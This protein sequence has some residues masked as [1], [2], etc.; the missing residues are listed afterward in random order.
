[1]W[2]ERADYGHFFYRIPD[3]ES[4]ADAYDRISGFN[5]SLWRR[6]D[7]DDFASVCILVTHGLMSRVFLMKWYHY[8]VEYF[9]DLRN[10][11]H[12]E[13]I[14]MRRQ[15]GSGKYVLQNKL[16]TWSELKRER[17]AR[18]S[19]SISNVLDDF[20]VP[21]R[22]QWG[23][24]PQGCSH[25]EHQHST[26][27]QLK[28]PV[29]QNTADLFKDDAELLG[30]K[31]ARERSPTMGRYPLAIEI[32]SESE[33][34]QEDTVLDQDPEKGSKVMP[35]SPSKRYRLVN[36]STKTPSSQN[37]PQSSE[38]LQSR[39]GGGENTLT[40]IKSGEV[41]SSPEWLSPL[42]R[43]GSFREGRDGGGS[44][45]GANSLVGSSESDEM[46]AD[47]LDNMTPP[48][49]PDMPPARSDTEYQTPRA[50]VVSPNDKRSMA[51]ALSGQLETVHITDGK[52]RDRVLA[53][54]LGDQSDAEIEEMDGG[55]VKERL[56]EDEEM[57]M[58]IQQEELDRSI[59]GS[60]Y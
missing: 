54:A 32:A 8:S 24:C 14:V 16:R 23:G 19:V 17:E 20:E 55:A 12:C 4:A 5:D 10:V 18:G 6:F 30:L 34:N 37:T 29:R 51:L 46:A 13:F 57:K 1:M 15:P 40:T 35:R 60:V 47:E 39:I 2:Q 48:S 49:P 59:E 45:S 36:L 22:R 21:M 7:E 26:R 53:D 50:S 56:R 42:D 44:R 28:M 31:S 25:S 41:A 52:G 33:D 3:G 38:V 9:E 27:P 11:N 43:R 58:L